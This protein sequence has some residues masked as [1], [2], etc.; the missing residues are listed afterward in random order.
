[1]KRPSDKLFTATLNDIFKVMNWS[2]LGINGDGDRFAD[3]IV[4]TTE[5]VKEPGT[6]LDHL[7]RV[8][9]Q[10]GVRL[11]IYKTKLMSYIHVVPTQVKVGGATFQVVDD[12]I[13]PARPPTLV[14]VMMSAV[15][16]LPS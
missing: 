4:I 8:S 16:D 7:A 1:M 6:A 2:G 9:G 10:I 14:E 5:V 3:D 11:N 12:F 13:Y 15:K